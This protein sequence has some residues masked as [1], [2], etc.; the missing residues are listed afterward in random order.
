MEIYAIR[1]LFMESYISISCCICKEGNLLGCINWWYK[2]NLE[3]WITIRIR[4]AMYLVL[5]GSQVIG[6]LLQCLTSL[7]NTPYKGN[8]SFSTLETRNLAY[9]YSNIRYKRKANTHTPTSH[10]HI[11]THTSIHTT[12]RY[13]YVS[14]GARNTGV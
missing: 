5:W 11:D 4:R 14:E 6:C 1:C 2:S 13:V 3:T 8:M 9:E 12:Q 10:T 7:L